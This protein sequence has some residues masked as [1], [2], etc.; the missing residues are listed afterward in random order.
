MIRDWP[1][2]TAHRVGYG[3]VVGTRVLDVRFCS[4]YLLTGSL[5][6]GLP[7]SLQKGPLEV[8]VDPGQVVSKRSWH[9]LAEG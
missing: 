3:H 6:G 8:V 4:D 2:E 5:S 7:A 1:W 9:R